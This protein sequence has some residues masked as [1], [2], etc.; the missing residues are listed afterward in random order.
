MQHTVLIVGASTAFGAAITQR[1]LA[2]GHQVIALDT[3]AEHLAKLQRAIPIDQHKRLLTL[4][5]DFENT[6]AMDTLL[7]GLPEPFARITILVNYVGLDLS[8]GD[9]VF[10]LERMMDCNIKAL[11]HLTRTCLPGMVERQLGHVINLG[12]VAA[13]AKEANGAV[14][15]TSR[16]QP[17]MNL[18]GGTR[19][20]LKQF[21]LNLRADLSGSPVRVTCVQPAHINGEKTLEPT[22]VAEAIY[23]ITHL[24]KHININLLELMPMQ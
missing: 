15:S 3:S 16:V 21:S 18:D 24:P 4:V 8:E 2:H 11:V 7:A 12:A 1:F 10:N 20:F 22:D 13:N 19:A 5:L 9:A 17:G 14:G 23:W 6:P